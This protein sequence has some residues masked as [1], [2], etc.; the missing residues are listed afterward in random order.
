MN[1]VNLNAVKKLRLS[2]IKKYWGH[3]DQI[4]KKLD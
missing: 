4:K 3:I 2:D 1:N